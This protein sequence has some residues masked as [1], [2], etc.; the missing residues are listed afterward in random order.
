MS[1][2][3]NTTSRPSDWVTGRGCD[4]RTGRPSDWR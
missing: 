1:A 2:K 4:K 3:K